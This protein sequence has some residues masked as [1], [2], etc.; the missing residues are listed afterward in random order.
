[1]ALN[2][3]PYQQV[4]PIGMQIQAPLSVAGYP[5]TFKQ[6][7]TNL[8]INSFD[9]EDAYIQNNITNLSSGL[10]ASADWIATADTGTDTVGFVDHGI[11][12]SGYSSATWTI[13]GALDAYYYCGGGHV[14]MGTDTAGKNVVFFTGGTLAANSRMVVS[15]TQILLQRPY[16][17]TAKTVFDNAATTTYTIATTSDYVYLTTSAAS[18]TVTYPAAAAAIDGRE[19]TLVISAGVATAAALSAGATFVAFP[20][21]FLANIPYRFKYDHASLKWYPC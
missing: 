11:N 9:T 18:L 1:M 10:S 21:A 3:T 20:A 5:A 19:I 6:V 16:S 7:L 12:C 4:D 8:Q 17:S 14:A 13:N 15:D 2:S